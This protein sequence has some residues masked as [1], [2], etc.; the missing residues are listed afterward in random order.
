MSRTPTPTTSAAALIAKLR[1]EVEV[2]IKVR[3]VVRTEELVLE[4]ARN[5]FVTLFTCVICVSVRVR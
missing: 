1:K 5:K 4:F 2:Q 3:K